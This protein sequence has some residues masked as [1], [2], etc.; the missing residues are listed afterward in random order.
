[1]QGK[2]E[3]AEPLYKRAVVILGAALGGDHAEVATALSY[4]AGVLMAPVGVAYPSPLPLPFNY[5]L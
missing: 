4:H 5:Y 2:D 3:E 1:M